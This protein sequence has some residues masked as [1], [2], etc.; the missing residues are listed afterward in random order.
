MRA[1]VIGAVAA[2][3]LPVAG[4]AQLRSSGAI[5]MQR[6]DGA[7]RPAAFLCDS[8]DHDWAIALSASDA[9][10]RVTLTSYAKPGLA[11]HRATVR[12][13]PG[14]AGMGHVW[15]TLTNV[16][17]RAVG[18]VE[19]VN[20]QMVEPG[21]TT[22]TVVSLRYGPTTSGCRFAAQTRVLG[23]T[24]R[25]SIQVTGN[26]R[27]GYRYR[28]YNHDAALDE[29]RAPWGGR[30]TRAS[31]SVD[32]G[33]VV[34]STRSRRTFQFERDGYVYRV[35]TSLDATQAG[36]SVQVWRDGRMLLEEPFAAYT[37]AM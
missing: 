24:A 36:G 37:A 32:G 28:S 20:P 7:W 31:V 14:D 4:G 13:G 6:V 26:E 9:Q 29:V 33:R 2:V 19:T 23:I 5:S 35:A 16:E 22:P 12:V 27:E 1:W 3:A 21:A 18:A 8:T 15:Y 17:G 10:G 11:T 25:R 34:D 30:D